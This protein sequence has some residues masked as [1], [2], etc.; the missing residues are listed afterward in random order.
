MEVT[1]RERMLVE[2]RHFSV[3]EYHRMAEARVLSEDD[4]VELIGGEVVKMAPIGSRHAACVC[5]L[6]EL[7]SRRT[8]SEVIV[9]VQN[10]VQLDESSELQL[11]VALLKRRDNF[12]AESHP[13]PSDVLLVVEV[14]DTSVRYDQRLKLPLYARAGITEAW[15]ID[16]PGNTIETYTEPVNGRYQKS[17]RVSRGETLVSQTIAGVRLAVDD[18][19]R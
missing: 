11:D 3:F 12:Y 10:P 4:R 18:V 5:R 15:L 6:T 9:W 2:K 7:F 14:A 13:S 19:L 17:E 1:R 16:L 8:G